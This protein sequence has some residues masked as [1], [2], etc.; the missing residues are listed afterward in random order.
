MCPLKHNSNNCLPYLK[1][2]FFA[3]E[4]NC[5]YLEID[6]YRGNKCGIVLILSE[7]KENA[8]LSNARI[9]D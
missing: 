3:V 6:A 9:A 4:F 1:F 2:D 8:S 7:S 5:A